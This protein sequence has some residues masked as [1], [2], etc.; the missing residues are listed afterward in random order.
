MVGPNILM[1]FP[2]SRPDEEGA[3]LGN[4][5]NRFGALFE[6]RRLQ[7]PKYENLADGGHFDQGIAGF[8]DN[9]LL[10]NYSLFREDMRIRSGNPVRCVERCTSSGKTTLIDGDL[11]GGAD[12]LI[13]VSF[14]SQRTDQFP[15]E[16]EMTAI[17]KFLDDPGHLRRPAAGMRRNDM[18]LHEWRAGQPPPVL[19]QRHA[20]CVVTAPRIR[21]VTSSPPSCRAPAI[22]NPPSLRRAHG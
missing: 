19:D 1:Y 5:D 18:D 10:A 12:I 3:P 2:W 9:I 13:V 16:S 7:W 15:N 8:F 4:L 14:D 17:R 11:L 21:R 22:R 6:L 20:A